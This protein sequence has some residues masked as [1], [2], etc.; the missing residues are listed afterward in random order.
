MELREELYRLISEEEQSRREQGKPLAVP[1][2]L[3]LVQAAILRGGK[4]ADSTA[5]VELALQV[6]DRSAIGRILRDGIRERTLIVVSE[7]GEE[8]TVGD[9]QLRAFSDGK[10]SEVKYLRINR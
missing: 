2:H 3:L 1:V 4:G 6:F 8:F 10:P 7:F 5:S 9:E